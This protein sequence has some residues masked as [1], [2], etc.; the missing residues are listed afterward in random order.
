ML[1]AL[2]LATIA[3]TVVYKGPPGSVTPNLAASASG[4]LIAT[5]LE[6]L[7]TEGRYALRFAS[8]RDGQG[9]S[10]PGTIRET[11]RFFVN[12]ADFAGLIDRFPSYTKPETGVIKAVVEVG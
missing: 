9:W 10:P 5:W 11:D 2:L 7:K 8:S 1:L 12:W 4:G 6:P 3:D